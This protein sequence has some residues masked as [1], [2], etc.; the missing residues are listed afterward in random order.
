MFIELTGVTP[1]CWTQSSEESSHSTDTALTH[2]VCLTKNDANVV[3]IV[4]DYTV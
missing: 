1:V 3:F 4:V 2:N